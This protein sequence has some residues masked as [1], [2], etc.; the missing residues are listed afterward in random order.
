MSQKYPNY[1]GIVWW[2]H[3]RK[4]LH[5]NRPLN[6][7]TANARLMKEL[8]EKHTDYVIFEDWKNA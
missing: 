4:E 6:P 1:G 8:R 5:V 2:N 3:Q 7:P